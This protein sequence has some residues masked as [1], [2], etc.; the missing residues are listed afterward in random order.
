MQR[1]GKAKQ[2]DHNFWFAPLGIINGPGF[3]V[4]MFEKNFFVWA[5]SEGSHGGLCRTPWL[6]TS[7][8]LPAN[9]ERRWEK[10]VT[11]PRMR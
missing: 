2:V 3:T 4:K 1:H 6:V 8:L 9:P 7:E 10:V 5:A 11:R